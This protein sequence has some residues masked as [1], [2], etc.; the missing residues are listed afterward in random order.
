MSK[1]HEPGAAAPVLRSTIK[2][3]LEDT[4]ALG[5]V[6][7]ANYLKFFERARTDYLDEYGVGLKGAQD[8][9]FRFVVHSVSVQFHRPAVLGDRLDIE[10]VI[11]KPSEYRLSFTQKA[12]RGGEDRPLATG[13][14]DVVCIDARGEVCEITDQLLR[15]I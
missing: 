10:T 13:K 6:Y 12:F 8:L 4:D 9:G 5:V 15:L 11:Q 14:V 3:Y 1:A 2:V 7:H